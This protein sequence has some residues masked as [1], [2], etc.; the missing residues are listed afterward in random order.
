MN[1]RPTTI[2]AWMMAIRRRTLTIPLTQVMSGLA[3]AFSVQGNI[4]W[5]LALFT[6]LVGICVTIEV[7]LFNDAIDF[8]KG[9]DPLDRHGQ[10]KVI[11]A[12]FLTQRQVFMGGMIFGA[13]VLLFGIPLI[14]KG[15]WP[16]ALILIMSAILGYCY[17][18]G[19]F[20][21]SYLGLSELLIMLFYGFLC[22]GAS[23]YVQI[24]H[25]DFMT[26]LVAT[27]MGCLAILPG[28]LNNFRDQDEDAQT[29]KRTLIVRFGKLFGRWEI[30]LLTIIPFLL[31]FFW[32]GAGYPAAAAMPFV[33]FP[34]AFALVYLIWRTEP[35]PI[36]NRFFIL[37]VL[38]HFAFG[39]LLS[40]AL[41]L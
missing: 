27:Q 32:I 35:G 34:M 3:L 22:I 15:G 9:G 7:N 13:L 37:C 19:P 5:M 40:T 10:V 12:G 16:I 2:Q 14:M 6:C 31:G 39:L 30:T 23:V 36:F 33:I 21:I 8:R 25:L 24:G 18:G 41:V 26:F 20:P 28:A 4:D 11:P 1:T 38:I 29:N 17:T